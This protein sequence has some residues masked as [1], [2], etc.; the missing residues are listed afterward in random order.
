MSQEMTRTHVV[1]PRSLLE[2]ID[3]QVGQRKRSEF[4]AE[5]AREKLDRLTLLRALEATAGVIKGDDYPEWQ[6]PGSVARWVEELRTMEDGRWE[7]QRG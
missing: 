7:G 5:A 2:A 4:L 3:G 6:D 1:L